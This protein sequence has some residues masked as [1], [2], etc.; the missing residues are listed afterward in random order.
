MK[1]RQ[2]IVSVFEQKYIV[3]RGRVQYREVKV[4]DALRALFPDEDRNTIEPTAFE[5]QAM[6]VWIEKPD[7]AAECWQLAHPAYY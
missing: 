1:I 6:G 7:D 5:L 2:D 3:Y 4:F